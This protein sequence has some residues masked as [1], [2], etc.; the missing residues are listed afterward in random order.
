M[1][2]E[3]KKV[4]KNEDAF[5]ILETYESYLAIGTIFN[6]FTKSFPTR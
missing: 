5:E 1:F 2:G 3:M 4:L 6:T